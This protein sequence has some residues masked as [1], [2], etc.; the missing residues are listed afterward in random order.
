MVKSKI[1]EDNLTLT[2][3]LNWLQDNFKVKKSG[4]PFNIQDAEGYALRG[5]IPKYLC[6]YAV[7]KVKKQFNAVYQIVE[8]PGQSSKKNGKRN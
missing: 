6:N 4:K 5:M 3:F 8:M 2:G 7:R 1:I